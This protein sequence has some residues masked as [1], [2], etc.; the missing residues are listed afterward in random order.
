MELARIGGIGAVFALI[1]FFVLLK[2]LKIMRED[3]KY[4]EDR[5]QSNIEN[6]NDTVKKSTEASTELITWLKARNGNH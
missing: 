2:V 1:V 5:M 6:Y 3:R 4:M